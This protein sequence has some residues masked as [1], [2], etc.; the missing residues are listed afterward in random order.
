MLRLLRFFFCILMLVFE[1]PCIRIS[2][3]S[4]FKIILGKIF[5]FN[6]IKNL[7]NQN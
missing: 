3:K 4:R 1:T 2:Q 5:F 7:V 6:L